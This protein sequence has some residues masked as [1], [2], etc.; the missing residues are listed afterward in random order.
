MKNEENKLP[1]DG[2]LKNEAEDVGADTDNDEQD[3]DYD[4]SDEQGNSR[5]ASGNKKNGNLNKPKNGGVLYG[6]DKK[7]VNA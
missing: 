1:T 5:N 4:D 2:Q 7:A 6:R 3:S